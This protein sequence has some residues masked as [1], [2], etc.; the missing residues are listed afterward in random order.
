MYRYIPTSNHK[1][2]VLSPTSVTVP[3]LGPQASTTSPA[4]VPFS[5]CQE[6]KFR[7]VIYSDARTVYLL[8]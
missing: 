2:T 7:K 4:F 1:V 6:H 3:L 8:I 5:K